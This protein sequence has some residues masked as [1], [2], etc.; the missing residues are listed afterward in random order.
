[1]EGIEAGPDWFEGFDK[2]GEESG[3]ESIPRG[4][5]WHKGFHI[6]N[7]KKKIKKS[8]VKK[9]VTYQSVW[10]PAGQSFAPQ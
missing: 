6:T 7:S 2:D 9:K 10:C 3:G 5:T 8:T 1:M 4:A